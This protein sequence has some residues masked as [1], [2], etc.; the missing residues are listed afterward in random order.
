MKILVL[1]IIFSNLLIAQD[2]QVFKIN[3]TFHTFILK[4]K[5]L[6]SQN[7]EKDC[8]ALSALKKIIKKK[9]NIVPF[10]SGVALSNASLACKK[11]NGSGVLGL[12][13]Q[14]NMVSFC[15]FLKDQSMIEFRSLSQK[16][17]LKD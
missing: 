1:F 5:V 12:D 4:E 15:F 17:L 10:K 7:C 11:L 14:Q 13:Q 2:L 9:Q 16:L 3:D 6:V 8:E